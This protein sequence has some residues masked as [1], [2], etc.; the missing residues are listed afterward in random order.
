MKNYKLTLN[1]KQMRV[2]K[3]VCELRF[4]IDL[5]Q[6]YELA[7]L[8]A[9]IDCLDL[10]PR[11]PNHKEIFDSY[12]ERRDHL[13]AVIKALYE[14]ASP[15]AFRTSNGRKRDPDALIA[16]D[17]YQVIRH[18]LWIDSPNRNETL[19]LTESRKPLRVSDQPLISIE[20]ENE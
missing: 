11:K 18:Q 9:K 15:I 3:D 1:E 6:E 4:R 20:V 13:T 17:I 5:L 19:Y 14:I 10:D 7:E 2:L 16:E 8:L 12:I